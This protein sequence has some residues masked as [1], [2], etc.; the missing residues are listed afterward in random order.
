LNK[1][2]SWSGKIKA[3]LLRLAIV[4]LL[5]VGA[6]ALF[7][8][9]TKGPDNRL[10]GAVKKV[11]I[12]KQNGRYS[13]HHSGQPFT[14]KGGAGFT[15]IKELVNCG[16]NT[17]ICWDTSKL[18][19]TF[20]EAEKN[21]VAV[22]IGLD[23]PGGDDED[24][25][26]QDSNTIALQSNYKNIVSRYKDEPALLAWCLGNELHM[27]VSFTT[28]PF[29][30]VY[31]RL[32]GMI[33]QTDPDHPVSTSTIN[34]AR[35]YIF[36]IRWRI[37]S[38]DF[39]CIN[40]YNRIKSIEEDLNSFKW[41]WNGPYLIGEWSP[42]GGWEAALTTWQA[43]IENTSTKKA[44]QY[45]EFYTKYMPRND[46]RFL[47]SLVFYWGNRHEYTHTWYSIFNED[48]T[49]TEAVEVLKDCW[50]DTLT[51]HLSPRLQYML[52]DKKSGSDN[53][54]FAAGTEHMASLLLE[55]PSATDTLVYQ[56]EIVKEDW[57]HWG[58]TWDNFKKPAVQTGLMTDSLQKEINFKAPGAEGPYRIFVT[59][60]NPA[61]FCAT[62]NT[63]F[64]VVQ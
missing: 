4:A 6:M 64:Y 60:K 21:N 3:W 58:L 28:I 32:L 24:F 14:V 33:H 62:A 8:Y 48:N 47:G 59:V 53:I 5:F 25:Y 12:N 41:V 44:E 20:I 1:Y 34:V 30:K 27:P 16:G 10:Q 46:P 31:N 55:K 51:K 52:I 43:P 13:F 50:K 49:P 42:N 17:I 35:R 56:W 45:A 18:A 38:L 36:N 19:G 26:K 61:G 37:P 7:F 11:A 54:I 40:T 15:H 22:I 63:P 23:I 39:I 29:Y 57:Q 9:C 2:Y